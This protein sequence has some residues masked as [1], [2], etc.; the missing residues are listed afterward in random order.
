MRKIDP[1][2]NIKYIYSICTLVSR[3]D[4]YLEM[5]SSFKAAGFDDDSCEYLYI[6]NISGNSFDGFSGFNQFLLE[7]KGKYIIICHQDILLSYDNRVKLEQNIAQIEQKDANWAILSNAGAAGPKN[8]I[9][10]VT[11]PESEYA[12]RGKVPSKVHSVD[13]SFIVIKHSANLAVSS[14]LNGFHFYGTDLCLVA[15]LLGYSSWVIDFNI[16]HKSK[17]KIDASFKSIRKE[18]IAK[19]NYF[20]RSR[21]IQTTNTNFLLSSNVL[22]SILDLFPVYRFFLRQYFKWKFRK[23]R[24]DEVRTII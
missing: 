17:G 3:M 19:Y 11:E 8:I 12:Q 10:R 22:L 7:A 23:V 13:E 21:Y 5:I 1:K 14:D 24:T 16:F 15:S 20:M 6:D 18:M 2:V 9:Y 4:E